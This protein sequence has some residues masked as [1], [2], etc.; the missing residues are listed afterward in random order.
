VPGGQYV[1]GY[2][3]V[4]SF[5]CVLCHHVILPIAVIFLKYKK[6]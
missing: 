2:V 6:G 4:S 5:G 3:I 1:I